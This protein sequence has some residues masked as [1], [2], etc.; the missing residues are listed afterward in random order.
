MKFLLSILVIF[1]S[2]IFAMELI[3]KMTLMGVNGNSPVA[4]EP[5][6]LEI[7]FSGHHHTHKMFMRMHE[8]MMHLIIIS[9]DLERFS[10][11][12]PVYDKKTGKFS[13]TLNAKHVDPDNKDAEYAMDKP[14]KYF[15]FFETMPMT[16][17]NDEPPVMRMDKLSFEFEERSYKTL[18]KKTS[19]SVVKYFDKN[20]NETFE[21]SKFKISFSYEN[22]DFC[23]FYKPKFYFHIEELLESGEY[24]GIEKQSLS[25]WLGMGGHGILINNDGIAIEE[26]SLFHLHGFLPMSTPGFFTLPFHS[27]NNKLSRGNYKI[28]GQ[29]KIGDA[30]RTIDFSFYYDFPEIDESFYFSKNLCFHRE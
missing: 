9:E 21:E 26:K 20:W 30:V 11:V 22:F 15:L 27:H 17:D 28:W 7:K 13:L 1:S 6:K 23:D 14:G 10:H 2:S 29:F 19:N 5:L 16:M 12:H 8:K 25:K 4:G 24:V 3:P 18:V